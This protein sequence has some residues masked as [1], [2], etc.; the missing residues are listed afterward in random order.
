[1]QAGS[2]SMFF[3]FWRRVFSHGDLA[4]PDHEPHLGQLRVAVLADRGQREHLA[5]QEVAV[6]FG[7]GGVGHA[8]AIPALWQGCA[9]TL[10]RLLSPHPH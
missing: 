8:P 3:T 4:V 1:M 9:A 10:R 2:V 6:A 5:F 7:D